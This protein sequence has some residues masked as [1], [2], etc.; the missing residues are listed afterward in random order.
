M[1]T[2][3]RVADTGVFV[4]ASREVAGARFGIVAPAETGSQIALA[5]DL[6]RHVSFAFWGD[7]LT[8]SESERV[9]AFH[10]L[11]DAARQLPPATGVLIF[12]SLATD[13]GSVGELQYGHTPPNEIIQSSELRLAGGSSTRPY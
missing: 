12:R 6:L 7:A 5:P 2:F 3:A 1:V 4:D 13:G 9:S 10:R 8:L 11:T